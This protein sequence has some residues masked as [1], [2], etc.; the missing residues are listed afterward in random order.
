MIARL[1]R[2]LQ[3]PLLA[4]LIA[5]LFAVT[6]PANADVT[7]YTVTGKIPATWHVKTVAIGLCAVNC[8]A[9]SMTDTATHAVVAKDG[10][11]TL[12]GVPAADF[13]VK[14]QYAIGP[15]NY[16]GYLNHPS[17]GVYRVE[18]R[19]VANVVHI[20]GDQDLGTITT[21]SQ[22]KRS[23]GGTVTADGASVVNGTIVGIHFVAS[24]IPRGAT[25]TVAAIGCGGK[26]VGRKVVR[27]AGHWKTWVIVKHAQDKFQKYISWSM[28]IQKAGL[29]SQHKQVVGWKAAPWWR[30]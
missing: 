28:T 18:K 29:V 6:G 15:Y 21:K 22:D 19:Y 30:C 14:I 12:T 23:V 3:I 17:N 7:T 27:S 1:T 24:H 10:S 26:A 16:Y 4:A 13:G 11:F 2:G 8:P 20:S 5:A 9:I 25:V